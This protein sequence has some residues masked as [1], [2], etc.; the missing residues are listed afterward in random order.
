MAVEKAKGAIAEATLLIESLCM[1]REYR[2]AIATMRIKFLQRKFAPRNF[3]RNLITCLQARCKWRLQRRHYSER[4]ADDEGTLCNR[5]CGCN[6]TFQTL[7]VVVAYLIGLKSN[8]DNTLQGLIPFIIR[9][10]TCRFVK[11][12]KRRL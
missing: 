7:V 6:L 8:F 11:F 9:V 5:K 12:T 2:C 3:S 4:A 1:F 10:M